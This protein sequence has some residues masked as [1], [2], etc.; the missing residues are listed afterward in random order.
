MQTLAWHISSRP[1]KIILTLERL[2][3]HSKFPR[4]QAVRLH[5]L[6][7]LERTT[8]VSD[9]EICVNEC[10]CSG[11]MSP[12]YAMKGLFSE[13]SDVFSFGVL[14]LEIISGKRNGIFSR[15]CEYCNLPKVHTIYL[16]P[17]TDKLSPIQ[18]TILMTFNQPDFSLN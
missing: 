10:A 18:L 5:M 8:S 17:I 15:I 14:L 11:Y 2:S 12:G 3:A 6:R 1:S 4:T 7:K 13:K 9:F 16:P